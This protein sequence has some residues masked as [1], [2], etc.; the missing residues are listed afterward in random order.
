MQR[1]YRMES[2]CSEYVNPTRVFVHSLHNYSNTYLQ[3]KMSAFELSPTVDLVT[4]TTRVS[5][6]R[7]LIVRWT[8]VNWKIPGDRSS[9]R[10]LD[11]SKMDKFSTETFF[12]GEIFYLF[13]LWNVN[14]SFL[15][16]NSTSLSREMAE[17]FFSFSNAD[18]Y[19]DGRGAFFFFSINFNVARLVIFQAG[20]TTS[21]IPT[22]YQFHLVSFG[23]SIGVTGCC[24]IIRLYE[25]NLTRNSSYSSNFS[26]SDIRN[27]L[28]RVNIIP[29]I[30]WINTRF[31]HNQ[32]PRSFI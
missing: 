3:K 17:S 24:L 4:D 29:S 6:S 16:L 22:L 20:L 18:F 26:P 25:S 2:I 13:L 7:D 32:R 14:F 1:Y 8:E 11:F 10:T 15:L 21:I 23:Y 28:L 30:H 9:F 27:P 31:S 5:F 19:F 12:Q